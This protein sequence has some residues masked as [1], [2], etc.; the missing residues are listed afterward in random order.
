[1]FTLFGHQAEV[2]WIELEGDMSSLTWSQVDTLEA[3]EGAEWI[4]RRRW[5]FEVKFGN[6]I[7]AYPR[8]I[9]DIRL[10]GERLVGLEFFP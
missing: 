10:N 9:S 4:A 1:M 5:V 3:F 2:A 7:A 6:L 8:R